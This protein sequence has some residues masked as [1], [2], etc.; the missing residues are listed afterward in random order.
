MLELLT[1][2]GILADILP[3]AIASAVYV[4]ALLVLKRDEWLPGIAEDIRAWR[5][6]K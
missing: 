4:A 3:W 2:E 1:I 6:R 5:R